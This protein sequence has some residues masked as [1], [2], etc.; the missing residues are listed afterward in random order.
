MEVSVDGFGPGLRSLWWLDPQVAFLNHG[1]FG[2]T[3]R[4]VLD[5]QSRWRERMERQPVHFLATEVPVLLR[6]AADELG[7]FIGAR[8]AD[9]VFVDNA[10]A[11]VNAVVSSQRF[12]AGD[13]ILACTHVY[14][15]VRKTMQ[16]VASLTGAVV[17]EVPVPFPIASPQPVIDAV[18][19]GL[20]SRTRLVILD[21]VT[22]PTALVLP[23]EA[24][25][26]ACRD[27]GVRVLV[28]GAHAP[29]MLPLDVAAIGA[30]WYVGNCHKWLFAPK[31]CAFLWAR[32]DRQDLHASVISH[33]YGSGF[34][35][36]FDWTGTKDPSPWLAIGEAIAFVHGLGVD[37][38][39]AYNRGMAAKAGEML[40]ERWGTILPSPA[41]MRGTMTPIRAP[42][43]RPGTDAAAKD[44]HD[45]LW[46]THRIEVPV[47]AFA[48]AC[49]VRISAQVYNGWD[50]YERLACALSP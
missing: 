41:S 45:W 9:L 17:V 4:R 23:V 25:V 43:G 33:G 38:M 34:H 49:W 15:A 44:L 46:D 18:I 30:D 5:A 20:T 37:R 50:D 12:S 3:P 24:I 47:I 48:G 7:Q 42:G 39:R 14:G 1:S 36:E 28:D 8:G 29:G 26:A 19:A 22:S 35:A 13:E 40:A 10:T 16:H 27:R 11:G 2:A 21:H 6:E 31:G 32:Q